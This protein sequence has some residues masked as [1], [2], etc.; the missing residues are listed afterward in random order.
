MARLSSGVSLAPTLS[1]SQA[2]AALQEVA[3]TGPMMQLAVSKACERQANGLVR[4]R[5]GTLYSTGQITGAAAA[6]TV[7]AGA[8]VDLFTVPV[9]QT[10]AGF[11]AN[12]TKSETNMTQAGQLV[13][14]AFNVE[15]FGVQVKVD[16]VNSDN[17][18][19]DIASQLGGIWDNFVI[20]LHLGG[21]DVQTLGTLAEWPG[22]QQQFVGGISAA[23]GAAGSAIQAG[24]WHAGY[25]EVRDFPLYIPT[26]TPFK[27]SLR[28][29][30]GILLAAAPAAAALFNIK[31]SMYGTS[32]TTIQG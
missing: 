4:T 17:I 10:G 29:P 22:I 6:Q 23:A 20:D 16:P 21:Q 31:V 7:A 30:R 5:E 1:A 3:N 26:A 27:V 18:G 12:L 9:G 32:I 2:S 14:E 28:C 15:K 24:F 25:Q 13:S 11:A 8:S 19:D